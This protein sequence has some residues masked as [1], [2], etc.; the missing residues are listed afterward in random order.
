VIQLRDL[1]SGAYSSEVYD[2]V[3][4]MYPICRSI[5]GDG[6]RET[7]RIIGEDITL[8][9]H[10]VPTG[11]AAFDWTIPKEWNI[12]DAY[13][14]DASGRRLVDF[15][16]C[17]L[18][19]LNYSTPIRGRFTR[20]ELK[21]HLYTLPSHPELIPYHTSYFREA[22]GFCLSQR[23]Y[24]ALPD[25]PLDVCIDSSLE[26]GHLTYGEC[27]LPGHQ[28]GE[29]LISSHVCH[30]SLCNDNLAGVS[31]AVTLARLL[32]QIPRRLS[33]RFIF[34]PGT[35]GAVTWLARNEATVGRIRHGLVLAC[36][37]DAG[38]FTYKQSRQGGAEIDR[39]AEYAL[40]SRGRE[41]HIEP[42]A[43]HG[44]DERQ[45]C[46]PGFNLPVGVFSRTSHDRF[47]GYHT[48]ADNLS[49]VSPQSLGDSLDALLCI[50]E[51]LEGNERFV[52][53]HPRCEPQL[54]RRGLY[55][56][57]GGLADARDA[58]QALLW[59]L[60]F[61]DGGHT[62]LDIAI[63]SGLGFRAVRAAADAL[64]AAGLLAPVTPTSSL[65][66]TEVGL[67]TE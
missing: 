65:S 11:T 41:A 19:V 8:E 5:T 20:E 60:N 17:N 47:P 55:T 39:V 35:I 46:S 23:Q 59:V 18:H 22:W 14:K 30:P 3:R 12:R 16:A 7:L 31:L 43:P 40:R 15:R 52:N 33:Y 29:V 44:Y 28:P 48:S 2:R 25:G 57:L 37:G 63:R 26:P 42:F 64:L 54:G 6:L 49:V 38:G 36:A 4:R 27:Y 56:A 51:I 62:L 32:A 13:I 67:Q 53:T 10:E 45:Y 34:A 21:A 9:M 58:E 50:V 66:P 61:S 24:D 1:R